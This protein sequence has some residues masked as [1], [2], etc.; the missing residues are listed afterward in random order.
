MQNHLNLK[1]KLNKVIV[2]KLS[3]AV[4]SNYILLNLPYYENIGDALIWKGTEDFLNK[5]PYKCI[6]KSSKETY[7]K[8]SVSNDI[9]IIIQGGGNWGDLWRSH[10]DFTL[11]ILKD[12]PDNPIIVLPQTAFYKDKNTLLNDAKEMDKHKNL[13]I[14]ARDKITYSLFSSYFN[15]NNI[16]LAPDMA[17][18]IQDS[19]LN[20]LMIAEQQKSLLL[21]RKDKELYSYKFENLASQ[22]RVEQKDWPSIDKTLVYSKILFRLLQKHRC[23][24]KSTI[25]HK[26]SAKII[27]WYAQRI[28]LPHLLKLGIKFI[29]KYDTIYSTRLH[30]AILAILLNKEVSVYDNSYGKNSSFYDCWLNSSQ[31]IKMIQK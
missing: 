6:Y 30:G 13:T 29:S 12:F 22:T 23:I 26:I 24:N 21:I 8:P 19:F 20:K 10:T 5:L 16:L 27:D 11:Q 18:C 17:F 28:Y 2:S 4:N 9:I 1:N 25:T 14:C 15:S 3:K 7:I 31:N